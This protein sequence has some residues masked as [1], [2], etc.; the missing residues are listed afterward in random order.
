MFWPGGI[1]GHELEL[2]VDVVAFDGELHVDQLAVPRR[3]RRRRLASASNDI[4]AQAT[5]SD[6][7]GQRLEREARAR[8]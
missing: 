6:G 7:L 1:A 5:N 2:H 3:L 8:A 4:D